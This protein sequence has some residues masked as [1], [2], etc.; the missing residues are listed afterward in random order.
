MWR[1]LQLLLVMYIYRTA[2]I[3]HIIL[4]DVCAVCL[5]KGVCVCLYYC[6]F[7]CMI[8]LNS[9]SLSSSGAVLFPYVSL[10]ICFVHPLVKVHP[11]L[12]SQI[13]PIHQTQLQVGVSR[14]I[15]RSMHK[16]YVYHGLILCGMAW[17]M[18]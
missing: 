6:A 10:Q 15:Q 5:C 11:L 13:S 9:A 1:L 18:E 17:L 14:S 8:V 7:A 3:Y 2:C 12:V 16:T 4:Y